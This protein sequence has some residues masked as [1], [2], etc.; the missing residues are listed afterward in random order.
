[1]SVSLCDSSV[2]HKVTLIFINIYIC[3]LGYLLM[4]Y[5]SV[6]FLSIRV[7]LSLIFP[8]KEQISIYFLIQW[9]SQWKIENIAYN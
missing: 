6:K 5:F 1:M 2:Y 9:I 7:V 4:R 8:L 3:R